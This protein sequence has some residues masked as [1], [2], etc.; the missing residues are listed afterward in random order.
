M[1]KQLVGSFKEARESVKWAALELFKD[2]L[3]THDL[4]MAYSGKVMYSGVDIKIRITGEDKSVDLEKMDEDR[5]RFGK[6]FF[7]KLESAYKELGENNDIVYIA[8]TVSVS[9]GVIK[10]SSFTISLEQKQPG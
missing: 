3:D 10:N 1:K 5:R 8:L 6:R 4:F 7:E 2:R 9:L